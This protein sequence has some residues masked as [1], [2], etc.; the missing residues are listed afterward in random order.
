MNDLQDSAA[1]P[2]QDVMKERLHHLAAVE[3]M[4]QA[5]DPEFDRWAETRLDRWLVDWA[6]RNGKDKTAR[7]VA[8]ET[9]IEVTFDHVRIS[10]TLALIL[11]ISSLKDSRGH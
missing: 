8:G 10:L 5:N 11:I 2:T 1:T 6:L 9:A 4:Q 3:A 7:K